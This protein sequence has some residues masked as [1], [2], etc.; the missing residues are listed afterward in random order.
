[1]SLEDLLFQ[2]RSSILSKWFEHIL[3][4]YPQD[5]AVFLRSQKSQFGNPV[6]HTIHDGL[7]GIFDDLIKVKAGETGDVDRFLDNIIRIRAVQDFSP[8]Q[9]LSFI[10]QLKRVIREEVGS[11][12]AQKNLA[13]DLSAF[14]D[15]IDTLMLLSF[16]IFMKCREKLYDL[17]ANEV[18]N[19][20]FR[21]LERVNRMAGKN[22]KN[23]E[24]KNST[25]DTLKRNE[26]DR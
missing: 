23:S 24:D 8:S 9:A 10:F 17:K 20:T 18:R 7:E 15:R 12:A 5:T 26:V 4:T 6:G 2:K 22:T 11:D 21:M 16:D 19:M 1:M 14:E 25:Y 13:E 3:D